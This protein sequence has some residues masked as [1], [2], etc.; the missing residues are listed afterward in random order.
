MPEEELEEATEEGGEGEAAEGGGS[1]K[2]LIIIILAV[3]LIGGAGAGAFFFISGSE[4]EAAKTEEEVVELNA[5]GTPIQ[6]GVFFYEVPEMLVNLSSSGSASRYLKIRV[7]LELGSDA[8]LAAIEKMMPRIID[9][10]QVYLRA[11]RVDDLQGSA[12]VYRLKEALLLR[13]NQSAQPI[14]VQAVLLKEFL[15][16]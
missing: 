8:D 13:A 10:F 5:D 1:S 15:I 12:G 3:V 7:N 11:L 6:K 16:Q 14:E 2:L 9:D 4:D